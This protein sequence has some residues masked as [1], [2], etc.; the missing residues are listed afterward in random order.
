MIIPATP[1]STKAATRVNRNTDQV[2]TPSFVVERFAI[3]KK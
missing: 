1:V 3:G 2:R